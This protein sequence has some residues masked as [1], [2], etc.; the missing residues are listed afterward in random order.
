MTLRLPLYVFMLGAAGT[1]GRAGARASVRQS[2]KHV[3]IGREDIVRNMASQTIVPTLR[4]R[5]GNVVNPV[6]IARDRS[7]RVHSDAL[8]SRI[9]SQNG[10]TYNV[11]AFDHASHMRVRRALRYVTRPCIVRLSAIRGQKSRVA[12][13]EVTQMFA[14]ALADSVHTWSVVPYSTACG[15]SLSGQHSRVHR[16]EVIL[17]FNGKLLTFSR[18]ICHNILFAFVIGCLT[19]AAPFNR[20]LPIGGPSV[21][22]MLRE[23][24]RERLVLV[25]PQPRVMQVPVAPHDTIS[26][27]LRIPERV[28][29]PLVDNVHLSCTGRFNASAF[30]LVQRVATRRASTTAV[31]LTKQNAPVN[32]DANR[33][34]GALNDHRGEHAAF[35]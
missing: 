31:H 8:V 29:S 1:I 3:R 15:L 6:S 33:R 19:D 34:C 7:T 30:M 20:M 4:L 14:R 2:N 13:Q 17:A 24:H 26:T 10:S 35:R 27:V 5:Q 28:V 22:R 9:I 21:A 11:R 12:V 23:Q 25:E 18:P 16:M 32:R